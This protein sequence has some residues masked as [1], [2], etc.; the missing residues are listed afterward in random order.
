MRQISH[1][2][3]CSTL[4]IALGI[5]ERQKEIANFR[6][7]MVRKDKKTWDALKGASGGGSLQPFS[8]WNLLDGHTC[9]VVIRG[10]MN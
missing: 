8:G 6:K 4:Q 7:D 5:K 2:K 3:L 10:I 1:E 9:Q